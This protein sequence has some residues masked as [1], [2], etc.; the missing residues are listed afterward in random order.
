M[1]QK[2]LQK[3]QMVKRGEFLKIPLLDEF[4]YGQDQNGKP[5][6]KFR[7]NFSHSDQ[8]LS[9]N[10]L[11]VEILRDRQ[12]KSQLKITLEDYDFITIFIKLIYLIT[13]ELEK[14]D[15]EASD[16]D[17]LYEILTVFKDWKEMFR[18]A[19]N[20]KLSE[21]RIIGLLGELWFLEKLI[22]KS[23]ETGFELECWQGPEG[24][25]EDFSFEGNL[26]EIK[27][28]KSTNNNVVKINSLRQINSEGI[29]TF[30]VHQSMSAALH[31]DDDADSLYKAVERVKNF[32]S[33]DFSQLMKF[34]HKLL[35]SSYIHDEKYTEPAFR[36]D[37]STFYE[38]KNDFP[39]IYSEEIDPCISNVRYS[40][41]LDKCRTF[42]VEDIIE[43]G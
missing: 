1:R 39:R 23:G 9:T 16:Q 18:N 2:T 33:H 20:K 30:L 10:L 4:Y 22:I 7:G 27:S 26:F 24:N 38:V 28:S 13:D 25:D 15:T 41:D 40:I 35:R 12:K 29:P 32:I 19:R 5:F 11:S 3:F 42:I 8:D 43:E 14:F 6:F 36:L 17:K 34:E 31:A 37:K 21:N